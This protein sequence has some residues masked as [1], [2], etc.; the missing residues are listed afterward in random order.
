MN[1]NTRI[2]LALIFG[3][4]CFGALVFSQMFPRDSMSHYL[5]LISMAIAILSAIYHLLQI[6]VKDP[7]D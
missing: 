4:I 6:E 3:A 5:C 1:K 2:L 7:E